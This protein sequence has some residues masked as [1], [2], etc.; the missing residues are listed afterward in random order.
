MRFWE[1]P[2]QP[3]I[4]LF[5]C[6]GAGIVCAEFCA[7]P[8]RWI[9][10]ALICAAAVALHTRRAPAFWLAVFLAF[11]AL[12]DF[13]QRKN[14]GRA[15][16]ASLG[17]ASRAVHGSGI[18][19]DEPKAVAP[20]DGKAP[21]HRFL[22]R[23]ETFADGP[24]PEQPCGATV[25]MVWAGEP[26]VY[27][28]RIAF[29]GDCEPVRGA[30]NPGEFD[31]ASYFHRLGVF[32][33]IHLRFPRD[34]AVLGHGHGNPLLAFAHSAR[35]WMQ[36]KLTLG[37]AD[38][39]EAGGLVQSLVLGL[40]EETPDETRQLFQRTGTLHLFVVNGLHVGMFAF[41][42][43][44][45][46]KPL[47]IR[48]R[49][50]ALAL[51][52]L[53]V[54]YATVT[55]LSPGSIRATIMAA[56]VLG[57]SFAERGPVSVNTLFAAGFAMLLWDTNELFMP[58]FQFSFGVVLTIIL[59]AGRIHARLLPLAAPDAFLP[60]QLWS[61]VQKGRVALWRRV[62]ALVA[63][64]ASASLGSSPFTA[65]YFHLLSPSALVAN[66][67][68]VPAAFGILFEGAFALLAGLVSNSLCALFNNVNWLLARAVL[69]LVHGFAALPGGYLF[70]EMPK[71]HALCEITVLDLG[72]GG[73][74]ALRCEGRNW[75]ID[76]GKPF[77]YEKSVRQ[78][79]HTRGVNRLDGLI[80]T[81]GD[82]AHIGAAVQVEDDFRP[83]EN[84]DSPLR[85][86]SPSRRAWQ[87]RL[88][89]D[90]LGRRVC[91]RG[92]VIALSE[93]VSARVLYPP[94]GTVARV[95]DDKALVLQIL[96]AG[97]RVLLMSDSGFLTERWLLEHERENLPSDVL[98]K[99]QHA[100]DISGTPDFL[101]A[102]RPRA[103]VCSGA[104]FPPAQQVDEAWAA[105]VAARG[106]ALFRQDQAG[107][108][109]IEITRDEWR[110]RAFLGGQTFTSRTR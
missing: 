45:I 92:D 88:A 79:L 28:D 103:V 82:V 41:I 37:L 59:L 49:A 96:A 4:G 39:P 47:G 53:L 48:R 34:G 33:K 12:H 99:G 106:I 84:V 5:F 80:L 110:A 44:F 31:A 40:K 108:V 85:D 52:A 77:A 7:W 8:A 66:L 17:G 62:A 91:G 27:G 94:P 16:A 95:A 10:P 6:A 61:M 11:F 83:R 13:T 50:L 68:I 78:F 69:L 46:L 70:V 71:K 102:V 2:R 74:A 63:V 72:A 97:T 100:T 36:E 109:R 81:H 42:A 57:A 107:A 15:L 29:T 89:A 75:L 64:T 93:N 90:G 54:F 55:G 51:I 22:A 38:A 86:R 43:A 87:A 1:Q 20:A 76:C 24:R 35:G 101:A 23:L 105:A 25:L 32:S 21:R 19:A 65:T 30:R 73:A 98:V 60:C 58:G 9:L 14:P 56:V 3:C 26:P 104:D 18:V 67:L